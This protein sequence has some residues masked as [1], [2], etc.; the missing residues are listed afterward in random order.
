MRAAEIGQ[1][2]T[3]R[4]T[5]AR[6]RARILKGTSSRYQQVRE[7]VDAFEHSV[8][9]ANEYTD[10]DR[11]GRYT[12]EGIRILPDRYYDD[13]TMTQA[14]VFYKGGSVTYIELLEE[15][16]QSG[17]VVLDERKNIMHNFEAAHAALIDAKAKPLYPWSTRLY[18]EDGQYI[19]RV[20]N[21][22]ITGSS[23][24]FYTDEKGRKITAQYLAEQLASGVLPADLDGDWSFLAHLDNELYTKALRIGEIKRKFE[25]TDQAF[26]TRQLSK[27]DYL[28]DVHLILLYFLGRDD[29]LRGAA[30]LRRLVSKPDFGKMVLEG[31]VK[32]PEES[33]RRPVTVAPIPVPAGR[34]SARTRRKLVQPGLT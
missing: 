33:F 17:E 11:R 31:T 16:V 12:T 20:E 24:A 2:Y 22:K 30:Y 27:E 23:V 4:P 18:S 5:A 25:A 13:P 21:G 3:A 6:T 19:F 1:G 26:A 7:G 8:G 9:S 14:K 29:G 10:Y 34:H 32:A 15:A 28:E